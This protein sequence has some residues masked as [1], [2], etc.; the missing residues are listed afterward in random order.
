MYIKWLVYISAFIPCLFNV[1]I[2]VITSMSFAHYEIYLT[3]IEF[4]G[5]LL[6]LFSKLDIP[7]LSINTERKTQ[8]Q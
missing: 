6:R 5:I 1:Y 3:F 7:T 2:P 8:F 4:A